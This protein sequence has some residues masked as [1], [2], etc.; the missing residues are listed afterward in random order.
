M[1]KQKTSAEVWVADGVGGMRQIPDL[2]FEGGDWPIDLVVSSQGA[3]AWMSHLHA[4]IEERGWTSSSLSQLDT[5]ENSG[6]L[7]V[8]AT[9]G[10]SPPSL[11]IVWNRT[12]GGDLR[13]RA[14]PTGDPP[15]TLEEVQIFVAN[16]DA[17]HRDRRTL[18][19]HRRDLM[20]Y[21]GLPWRGEVWLDSDLR[22][23]P[24]SRFP[25]ALLGPQIVIVDAMCEGIGQQGVT[26]NFRVLISEV[27][28]FISFVLGLGLKPERFTSAWVYEVGPDGRF[29]D[30]VLRSIGYVELAA[31]PDFPEAGSAAPSERRDVIRPDI[32]P[33]GVLP[34]MQEEWVPD[35]IELLWAAF[36]RLTNPKRDQLIHAGNAYLLARSLWPDHRT[37]CATFFVVA[38]EA[39]KPLGK[40]NNDKGV[41]DVVADL[42]GEGVASR[43]RSLSPNPQGVRDQH[44]HRGALAA[45]ELFPKLM[46]DYF[47]DPSFHEMIGELSQITRTC[48]I[49][50]LR[51]EGGPA[52]PP[53][54]TS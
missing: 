41:Y 3:E 19:A 39:L 52:S 48:L 43:L 10:P 16:V 33:L 34:D 18:R 42:L 31:Q 53:T 23:G 35:D 4:E 49:E 9:V 24:P 28:V 26:S 38:C 30:C 2:R 12:R 20:T 54:G 15:L 51:R 37:A 47:A 5:V 45:G 32:G 40:R 14:Q 11:N 22:L 46:N 13:V 21:D 44:V 29:T 1:P 25:E 17:R 50:W 7:T 6:T 8:H 36:K 27:R